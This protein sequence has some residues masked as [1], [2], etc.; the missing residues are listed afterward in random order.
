MGENIHRRSAELFRR[1]SRVLPGG[2]SRNTL[3]RDTPLLYARQGSGC[4]VVDVDGV[5]RI[6]FANNMASLIHGHAHPAIVAA[7][8]AQLNL[9][10]AFTMATE[11]E[12]LYAEQLCGRSPNFDKVRFVNSGTEAVMTAMKAARA[13]TGRAKIAKVE[14]AYHGTYDYAEASQ[15]PAP[16]TWGRPDNPNSVPLAMGTPEGV[17]ADVV[18]IPFNDPDTAVAILDQHREGIA[19]VLLDL[20]P[21]RVG[22]IPASEVFVR[23]LRDWTRDNDALL[24]VDEVITFR[25]EVG[26]MQDRY[27]V[28]PD[29]TAMAKII[30]GG[31]PVGAVAGRDE[32]M[33]VFAATEQGIR[34]PHSGTFSAN[35]VTMTAGRV[36]MELYDQTAVEGLNKLGDLAR[37]RISEAIELSGA[38]ASVTGSGSLFRIHMRADPPVDY[39][40]A[41]Q[42]QEAVRRLNRFIDGVYDGG[43]MMLNTAAG[44]LSTAIGVPEI[45]RL[46]EVVQNSLRNLK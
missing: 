37:S 3:L 7:V 19:G 31:F 1:A 43:I 6:D 34:L 30:G 20:M 44:A 8:T 23:A 14:G 39:R 4:R 29:L 35:P 16:D 25:E 17:L 27:T 21:H 11:A 15:S 10:T 12:L 46:A 28:L 5:E 36:A 45:D 9:G 38:P 42:D 22:L 18:I 40:S 13:F 24:I 33:S 26:G 32:V 2:V 41:Y